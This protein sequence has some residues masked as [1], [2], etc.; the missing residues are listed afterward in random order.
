[1]ALKSD[2]I[3]EKLA[4]L[5]EF[6][7]EL[8][9]VKTASFEEYKSNPAIKRSCERLIQLIVEVAA[10]IN[11]NIVIG[12]KDLPPKD[13]YDTFIK[14]SE[15]KLISSDLSKRLA[16]WAG[17]RNRIVHEYAEI[18]D[19]LVFEKVEPTIENFGEYI[20]QVGKF[21]QGYA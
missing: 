8:E 4:K 9:K 15:V 1:L 5:V 14:A 17:L 19:R 16:P 2:I 3:K 11:S 6:L 12:L 7:R 20:R 18:K 10:D 13:Y 21:I